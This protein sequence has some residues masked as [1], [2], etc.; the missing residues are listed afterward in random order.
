MIFKSF[1]L[2]NLVSLS[3][4]IIN[5]VVVVGLYY[6]FL[7]TFSIGPSYIFLLR[8]RVMEE[9][10][11]KKVSATTGFITG[12]LMMFISIYYA[13]LY[14]ALGR[15]HTITV[16]A[17]PYFLFL[18]FWNNHKNFCDY[19]S[20]TTNTNTAYSTR[21]LS[22][23]CVFLNNLIFQLFNHFLLPSS[24][25]VRLVNIYMFRCNNKMLFVTS[26]FVG[27]LIGHILFM[28][29]VGFVLVWIQQNNYIRSNV[30]IR[31][32][33]YLV[34]ELRN[35]MTRVLSI[36]LFITCV[37]Y[38]GRI[39]S[40]LFSTKLKETSER[41]EKGESEEETDI[42]IETTSETKGT[43]Q[44]QEESTEEDSS[45]YLFS[46][47]LNKIDETKEIKV[48]GKEKTKDEF[49]FQL[50]ETCSKNRPLYVYENEKN[51]SQT[52][53]V[54]GKQENST[55]EIFKDKN[56]FWFEKPLVTLLFDYKRWNRP[57]R[58]RKNN[59]GY[60]AVRNEMSQ[61]FFYT[62]LSDGNKN[63]SFTYPPSLAIF[64]NLVE[65]KVPIFTPKNTKYPELYNH[66]TSTN[67]KKKNKQNN[68]F[69]NRIKNLDLKFSF[70]AVIKKKTR[71]YKNTKRYL[72]KI[73]DPLL[74][75]P[76]R[77]RIKKFNL[78]PTLNKT[79]ITRSISPHSINRINNLFFITSLFLTPTYQ[80]Q[81]FEQKQTR[82]TF[83]IKIFSI[84]KVISSFNFKKLSAVLKQEQ[85]IEDQ[86][87]NFKYCIDT[88]LANLKD[89]REKRR[90]K[91]DIGIKEIR[92]KVPRWSYKI[93]NELEYAERVQEEFVVEDPGIRSRR[94]KRVIL[95]AEIIGKVDPVYK[96]IAL[97]HYFDQS[98]FRRDIIKG[99]MRP[100]RRKTFTWKIFH[101]NMHSA[102]FLDRIN[103]PLLF[104][105]EISHMMHMLKLM[106]RKLIG[107]NQQFFISDY[108]EE[109]TKE[110]DK[111]EKKD[112]R[113]EKEKDKEK[114]DKRE[115]EARVKKVKVWDSVT[116]S[117]LTRG[118]LLVTKSILRKYIILPL[119]IIAKNIIRILL[120][121]SPEWSEDFRDLNREIHIKCTFNGIP[122]P[123]KEFPRNWLIEGIQIK[124]LFPFRLKP[125]H[126]SKLQFTQKD[127]MKEKKGQKKI[128]GGF[129]TVL[130]KTTESPFGPPRNEK[131]LYSFDFKPIF[132]KLEKKKKMLKKRWFLVIRALKQRTK[133]FTNVTKSKERK[134]KVIKKRSFSLLKFKAKLKELM[135]IFLVFTGLYE[136]NETKKDLITNNQIIHKPSTQIRH[137][138]IPTGWTNSSLP[139][140]RMQDLT[141]RTS[142][143]I[144]QIK[145]IT[146]KKKKKTVFIISKTKM[147]SKKRS[148]DLKKLES[149]I[150][151]RNYEFFYKFQYFKKI[152][153]EK[154]AIYTVLF[155]INIL[156]MNSQLFLE[157]VRN[158]IH[159]NIQDNEEN[160]DKIMKLKRNKKGINFISNIKETATNMKRQVFG[161]L[162]SLSQAYIFYK[163]SQTLL[164]NLYK[165]RPT[166]R[167]DGK[168]F[169]LKKKRKDFFEVQGIFH[170]ELRH[171]KNITF[172]TNPWKNW[173]LKAGHYQNDLS[174]IRWSRLISK[175]RINLVNQRCMTENK[176]LNKKDS[177]EKEKDLL[178][179]YEKQKN[180]QGELLLKKKI[181]KYSR[182]DLL[183]YKSINYEDPKDSSISSS[184]LSLKTKTK[185]G[186]FYNF[187]IPKRKFIRGSEGVSITNC[188]E[189]DETLEIEQ[190]WDRKYLDWRIFYF[191][192]K[193]RIQ[194]EFWI[195]TGTKKKKNLFDWMEMNER[196]LSDSICNLELWLFPKN[197]ILYNAYKKKPWTI[198]I[199]LLL[200]DLTR[201]DNLSEKSEELVDFGS[202]CLN[203]EKYLEDNFAESDM[204]KKNYKGSMEAELFLFLQRPLCFQLKWNTSVKKKLVNTMKVY[205]FLLKSINP[206]GATLSSIQ[207]GEIGINFLLIDNDLSLTEFLKKGIFI[208]EPVRL[209][210]KNGGHFLLYQT[211]KNSLVHKNKQKMN[212]KEEERNYAD[213][214][215]WD[216]STGNKKKNYYDLLISEKT[217][218]PRQCREL[219]ILLSFN[220]FNSKNK[221]D[222]K[223][224]NKF[225]NANNTKTRSNISNK[226]KNISRDNKKLKNKNQVIKFKRFLWPNFRLEDL[227]CMN[228]YWFDT[229]NGSRFSMVRIH[230][231]PRLKNFY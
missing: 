39:P 100:Q 46:E 71:L 42:E 169:F 195:D 31:S 87:K 43:K 60:K 115:E 227:A 22:I 178:M 51:E 131:G 136:L 159:K 111:K 73:Y 66:W 27:W 198:P 34:S 86:P 97:R 168:A 207:R 200:F 15:P 194:I 133:F 181:K 166:L 91:N 218:S 17:L 217:L 94:A 26:S 56:I 2:G 224:N 209:A 96:E 64:L 7:T 150:K 137:I 80:Y 16:L 55:F 101:A 205:C 123:E 44:E 109:T 184:R 164:I 4:K 161:D 125:W 68:E 75:G 98:D 78:S 141:N 188:L 113:E 72:P 187:T 179:K 108:P 163:I 215:N 24:M 74:N 147:N 32:N 19:G 3:L 219:R 130:G 40:P 120:F 79:S 10:T 146:K 186:I 41:E 59:K 185:Q 92:K 230:L 153:I 222:I 196:L 134:K 210:V 180:F 191:F 33:K 175:K 144:T 128:F 53:E 8:A 18:F 119:L 116:F 13:P 192:L 36:L 20:T 176:G 225:F 62:C 212:K 132:K 77:G 65:G 70:F 199:K 95:F 226:T 9:G 47:D 216:K 89:K 67:E 52:L 172:I 202:V 37:Y 170:S 14:L 173:L 139:E 38:L 206:N 171:K 182:Y 160:Q 126:R 90:K 138:P 107:K 127:P 117:Q 183:A 63:I 29:W 45:S 220:S 69:L 25:L 106:F 204:K 35:S 135:R 48:N 12:Q 140:K 21:N 93:I 156:R 193:K 229:N 213:T 143:I 118:C 221:K 112:K 85:K 151:R 203:Q 223:I 148:Y 103:K 88:V 99:S 49:H 129:L 23:Q 157:S 5:S 145:K 154:K 228:R 189:E 102:L 201:N 30:L 81:E 83:N 104:S 1:I 231:Y 155:I 54:D 149:R 114:K 177:C 58:Y 158:L 76:S 214:K 165:L 105:F 167:D 28:K 208:I 84:E 110:R 124:I 152:C 174:P 82:D 162:S 61:Y 197:L 122:L 6:G 142:T 50:K 57:L 121:Q 11:E 190:N 211:L